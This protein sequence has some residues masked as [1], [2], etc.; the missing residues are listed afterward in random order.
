MAAWL[1]GSKKMTVVCSE[2]ATRNSERPDVIGWIGGAASIL[3]ECKV[4]R[5]DFF[6]DGKKWFRRDEGSGMGDRRYVAAPKGLLTPDEMPD[7]WG[8]LEVDERCVREAREAQPKKASKRNECVM[9]M[10]ALRR[11]EIST[12]VYVVHDD[13]EN[14]SKDVSEGIESK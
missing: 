11:L 9:L 12:A 3:I 1:K 6:S 13:T 8:L 14:V 10:S 2:L 5:G 7:G 4:S